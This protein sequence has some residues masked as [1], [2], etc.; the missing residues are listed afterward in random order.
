[1]RRKLQA[2]ELHWDAGADAEQLYLGYF[3][4]LTSQ[5]F[6]AQDINVLAT[7]RSSWLMES[8]MLNCATPSLCTVVR[9]PPQMLRIS[10]WARDRRRALVQATS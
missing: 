2:F 4:G 8:S 1:M 5:E 6:E 10:H 3:S 7:S 9:R